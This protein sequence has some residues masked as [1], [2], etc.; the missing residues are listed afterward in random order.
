MHDYPLLNLFWTMLYFFLWV[1]WIFLLIRILTDIF[2]SADLSGFGK[3]AWT[4]GIIVLPFLG[5]LIYVIARGSEMH[6]RENR[7]AQANQEAFQSYI[8]QAA[9]GGHGAAEELSK[10]A[11]LRD[12]GVLTEDEFAAQKAKLL[13]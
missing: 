6:T 12:Q 7:A 11:A 13:A 10:L 9:G 3:F 4:L 1:L 2:R 5:V 8:K